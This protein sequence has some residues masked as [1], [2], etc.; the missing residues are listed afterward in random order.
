LPEIS[1]TDYFDYRSGAVN[2]W[3]LLRRNLRTRDVV[4]SGEAEVEWTFMTG[5]VSAF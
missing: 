5:L 4:F 3:Y 1:R 2:F